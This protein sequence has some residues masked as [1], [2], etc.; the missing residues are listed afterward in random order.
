[1]SG[2][3][4]AGT[5]G[6]KRA[7]RSPPQPPPHLDIPK[8]AIPSFLSPAD[9]L[10]DGDTFASPLSM[11]NEHAP[12][13][14]YVAPFDTS[15]LG[16]DGDPD[17]LG[18][19]GGASQNG[20]GDVHSEAEHY[21]GLVVS[22]GMGL[23]FDNEMA[24][25][26]DPSATPL[27]GTTAAAPNIAPWLQE[28]ESTPRH[29]PNPTLQNSPRPPSPAPTAASG[30]G[31]SQPP[32]PVMPGTDKVEKR[33][34]HFPSVPSLPRVLRGHHHH[35]HSQDDSEYPGTASGAPSPR[36]GSVS[37][38]VETAAAATPAGSRAPS[39]R[40]STREPSPP[41]FERERQYS[42]ASTGS[43]SSSHST[44]RFARFGSVAAGS[45]STSP[46]EKKQKGG[47]FGLLKR[48]SGQSVSAA[49]G[50]G[51]HPDLRPMPQRSVTGPQQRLQ[52]SIS[53]PGLTMTSLPAHG[54]RQA[55][56][57]STTSSSSSTPA[58]SSPLSRRRSSRAATADISPL[59]EMSEPEFHID[60]DLDDME[61]IVDPTLINARPS[62]PTGPVSGE[63][64]PDLGLADALH[65]T[66]SFASGTDVPPGRSIV[67]ES[68]GAASFARSN[69]FA[70]TGSSGGSDQLKA[71][72]H[73]PPSPSDVSPKHSTVPGASNAPRRPSQLRNV[74]T[75]SIDLSASDHPAS[76]LAPSWAQG[77][78][79]SKAG[80]FSDPFGAAAG[81]KD[82]ASVSP[83]RN[84]YKGPHGSIAPAIPP[85]SATSSA[86]AWAAPESWG[87]EGDELGE[88]DE[89][90]GLSEDDEAWTQEDGDRV[91]T[92]TQLDPRGS[93]GSE[94][95]AKHNG[96][97]HHHHPHHKKKAGTASTIKGVLLGEAALPNVPHFTRI[98]LDDGSYSI[99]SFLPTTTTAEII[100]VLAGG[101]EGKKVQT[102]M[103]L[104]VREHGQDRQLLPGD[105]PLGLQARRLLQAG[106][107]EA[108]HIEEIGKEDL[109]MLCKFIYQT[110]VLPVINPE[111]ESAYES[112][113]FI[114]L[115]GRD[116]QVIP[117]F[118]H[119]HADNIIILNVSRNPM[120]D[121]PLD[122]IDACTSL[123]ELR[124]SNMALKRV[125]ASIRSSTTLSR[126]DLS[127]NR[128]A[129]LESVNLSD[130]TTLLSLKVQNNRLSSIP[131]YFLQMKA[132]KYL[133]ISNNVFEKFP[134]VVCEMSN[135]VDLDV[136]FNQIAELPSA[137]SN[138]K[139]LERLT[140][141]GNE[142]REFPKSFSTLANL[143]V[144]DVR[145]NKLIDLTPVYAL[146]NLATLRADKND[147]VTLDTQLGE[148]VRDFSVPHNS[149]TRF[150]LACS[151][152]STISYSLT[153][154]NLSYGKISVL[155]D[156]ALSELVNLVELNLNFNQFNR[157]P[158]TLDKLVN[159]EAFSCT[160]NM[161]STFPVGCLGNMQKL[162]ICNIHNNNLSEIPADLWLCPSIEV[163]NLSSNLL[164]LL[165]NPPTSW[166]DKA[167]DPGRKLS[168]VSATSDKS[169]RVPP[170]GVSLQSLFL[171]DNRLAD[172]IFHQ[173]ALFSNLK[174]LNVSFN[175]ILEIPSYTLSR[176][177]KLEQL[178]LSGNKLTS[179]PSEDLEQLANLKVLHVNG[180][181]LQTLP[182]ELGHLSHLSH[183]DVGSN[184]LK[185]NISNWP[186]D[187]NW[188]W[189]TALRY[190]NLSGNKRLEIKP[191]SGQ[192]MSHATVHAQHAAGPRKDLSDFNGLTNLRVLG[193]MDVTLRI[194]SLPDESD[195]KR[196]RTS[197]SEINNMAYG[198][199]DMLGTVE[200]LAMFDL[201]VPNFRGSAQ[202]C[203]FGMFGRAAPSV[204]AGKIPKYLQENF[205]STLADQLSLLQ[206]AE[207]VTEA[208]RRTFLHINKATFDHLS[209]IDDR[210]RPSD[211]SYMSIGN[212][213]KST[214][215]SQLRTG[216]SGAVVYV[217][218]KTLHVANAGDVL[219]VL[220][221][222]GDAELLS[223]RHDPT[224][225]DESQRIR[226][227]E[228]WVSPKGLVNDDK[229]IEISRAFG[230]YQALPAVNASP[231]VRTRT[232]TET[233]EFVIIGNSALW[234]CCSYQ[235]AVDIARTEKD[236]PMMAAQKLRDFAISY[237]AE[238]SV[239]VMVVNVNDL[240][241]R[242]RG[243]AFTGPGAA[244]EDGDFLKRAQQKRR[245]GE[246]EVGDRTLNRLQQEI[247]PPTGTVAIVFTD[248][249]NS[250]ALWETNPG[251][252]T[253]IK[254]HHSFMRRQLRLDGGYEV[255]TE[256][257]AF[258]VSF[259]SVTAA[260]LWAFNC[261]IGLLQQEW[262]RELLE[263]EDGK[264]IY[265]SKGNIIHRGLRVRMGVHW[266]SPECEVD[267]ITRRMDYY[268]PMVNRS[269]RVSAGADGGQ[270][271]ASQDVL[272]VI[273]SLREYIESSDEHSLD[274]LPPDVKR[275]V[276]EL[277]RIGG[278]EIKEVG[279]RKL[280]GLEVPEKLSVLFPKTLSGRL[281]LFSGLR[282]NVEVNE[283]R[284][285]A[286]EKH[287]EEARQLSTL[288]LRLEALCALQHA[289]ALQ[290]DRTGP[291][292]SPAL[293]PPERM[294][295]AS[296]RKSISTGP[297]APPRPPPINAALGP[298]IRDNITEDELI[299]VL[300][301][302]TTRAENALSTLYLK[303]LGGFSTVLAALE[304]ATRVDQ[305]LLVH[306][307]SL[308]NG[309]MSGGP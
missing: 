297:G 159:L 181:K 100:N 41:P 24:D 206:P 78:T 274:E 263:S 63:D 51:T 22:N 169:R 256:G 170:A 72:A 198:I 306:A 188:N 61:G 210:H 108:E 257:D 64:A 196:V 282:A 142:L 262:P 309:A 161:L 26:L 260:L 293:P 205:S 81:S 27:T 190:L 87:V 66:S 271:M 1:M 28:D 225:R 174:V 258:M 46:V 18:T 77:M 266:G 172:E 62:V 98:Y 37:S 16:V 213:R 29:T 214:M 208:L 76:P 304:K 302:L 47:I 176:C 204:P 268:G 124:M 217:V 11:V 116:L 212:V 291:L 276:M 279:E 115:S 195:E 110:P 104:Y 90:G 251:M 164:Q 244:P 118:L 280:K 160:D 58:F 128:I 13:G 79:G 231:E 248:I 137:M 106:Y 119:L 201:A 270:L 42:I 245:G 92:P 308:M 107:T 250:T 55:S 112:F 114:D 168:V 289:P 109:T 220:S 157:L 191:S 254:L 84:D 216:S 71:G 21:P 227:A 165:P 5:A 167:M 189:N 36:S 120:T 9:N 259:Q 243:R 86:A 70:S 96:T 32:T 223:R 65:H 129:D 146:P 288:V 132:L 186:Y 286:S 140:C 155:D 281:E 45:A 130:I 153:H 183:L 300:G 224:E 294:S 277:R 299:E 15:F 148:K 101:T 147:L 287:I 67:Q 94:Q 290:G 218:D 145:R 192:E 158:Q 125:P 35:H 8:G 111:E 80:F 284:S 134:E 73:T 121:L 163:I 178:Y 179:L 292:N 182:A 180:N 31:L 54:Q 234:K 38:L 228:A 307:L 122:F 14:G 25:I 82:R 209:G 267:P 215:H 53:V 229:E 166:V 57:S 7:T 154:L 93:G 89:D 253:A 272:N 88:D 173:I 43:T 226:R 255:K 113:E 193:L 177:D 232:L 75:D 301:S 56:V 237:G 185:Y 241:G 143:R 69:P 105:R 131:S 136:S 252:P 33:K 199:S 246:V 19:H 156:G 298:S 127:C 221:R 74:K 296:A 30:S 151:P 6:N 269:A 40:G 247:E 138:L 150:T 162:R 152:G 175:E 144:L 48:K 295:L 85:F 305:S 275:E 222:K 12:P 239:M 60:M 207:G 139:S 230:F 261:Q 133:N 203:L 97:H 235:T 249:V 283:A 194:P 303:H 202:E 171:A 102:S 103:K 23:S 20:H 264:I 95:L 10:F 59:D 50:F 17:P 211:A 236:D 39:I 34:H 242:R 99:M 285:Y 200:H 197:F 233:D 240:F 135:L 238:G 117:I 68:T 4:P 184:V 273:R 278:I 265:D 219:V 83:T 123:K 52:Q 49:S 126:L 44:H 91:T 141:V 187:W 2:P 3:P 149:I